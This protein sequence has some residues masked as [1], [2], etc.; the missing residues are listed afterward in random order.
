MFRLQRAVSRIPGVRHAST[1]DVVTFRQTAA[2]KAEVAALREKEKGA[3]SALTKEEKV[4][5]YRYTFG[6]SRVEKLAVDWNKHIYVLGGV[7]SGIGAS[8]IVWAFFRK[9]ANPP[10][11]TLSPEWIAEQ[12]LRKDRENINPIWSR[13]H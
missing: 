11:K 7:L 4:K 5:L 10:P 13:K 9:N 2:E 6:Q 8:F 12:E 3:W 1:M